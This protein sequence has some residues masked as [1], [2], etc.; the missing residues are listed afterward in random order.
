MSASVPLPVASP[1]PDPDRARPDALPR[2][3]RLLG[4]VCKLISYG[5]RLIHTLQQ[6]SSANRRDMAVLAFGTRDL[7]RIIARIKCGLLRAAGLEAR[8]NGYV[9]RGRD[10]VPPPEWPSTPCA[11]KAAS[12]GDA[13]AEVAR[14]EVLADLPTTEEI[15]AQVRSRPLGT[16]I[17]DICR[18]LGLTPGAIDSAL[19]AELMAAVLECGI[20]L[21]G[22][23]R[24]CVRPVF[25]DYDDAE[26]ALIAWDGAEVAAAVSGQPP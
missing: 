17:G 19:W 15:A 14:R 23:M 18:D 24:K 10:L 5:T 21:T 9:K 13:K 3:G 16:V 2:I 22:F 25:G 4:I 8:L 6:G 20:E 26:L 7:A 12:A 11:R 1:S